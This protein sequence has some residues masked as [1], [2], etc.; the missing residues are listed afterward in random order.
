MLAVTVARIP[1]SRLPSY[2]DRCGCHLRWMGERSLQEARNKLRR[3]VLPTSNL[4]G[5]V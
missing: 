4:S 3:P 1:A 2:G 5:Q